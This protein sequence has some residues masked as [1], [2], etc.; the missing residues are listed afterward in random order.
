M[1]S[2]LPP[3]GKDED[4][5]YYARLDEGTRLRRRVYE[6]LVASECKSLRELDGLPFVRED[7]LVRDEVWERLVVLGVV[8]KT[9][10]AHR[11]GELDIGTEDL[12]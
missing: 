11:M 9:T 10:A 8:R 6:M 3:R 2:T 1:R 7:V 4:E 5:A 12:S